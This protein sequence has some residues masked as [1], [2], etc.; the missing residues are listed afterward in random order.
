[1]HL[2]LVYVYLRNATKML[3]N[4]VNL[5]DLHVN[6]SC[7]IVIID[8]SD[9]HVDLSCQIINVDLSCQIINVNLYDLFAD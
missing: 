7:Q 4:Y 8:L 2:F 1:M 5:S 6:F 9:L 3:D